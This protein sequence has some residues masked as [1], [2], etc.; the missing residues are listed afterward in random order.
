MNSFDVYV[1][2]LR[3]AANGSS[4]IRCVCVSFLRKGRVTT[5]LAGFGPARARYTGRRITP[6]VLRQFRHLPTI[7]CRTPFPAADSPVKLNGLEERPRRAV[8]ET[9]FTNANSNLTRHQAVAT[10]VA[11]LEVGSQCR[12]TVQSRRRPRWLSQGAR[13]ARRRGVAEVHA[14]CGGTPELGFVLGGFVTEWLSS[15]G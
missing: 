13:D 15:R 10:Q 6:A 3:A 4:V 8:Y 9:R 2:N 12:R 1:W 14:S 11:S 7:P 5:H